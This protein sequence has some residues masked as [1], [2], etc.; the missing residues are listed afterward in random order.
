MKRRTLDVLFSA[1]GLAFA[2][3]FV[4]LGV[5]LTNQSNFAKDYV[6]DQLKAQQI[7]FTPAE[8]LGGEQ[9]RPG[10]ECLVTY[11][12]KDMTTGKMAEC[13]ANQY[14]AAHVEESVAGM[15][16]QYNRPDYANATYSSLGSLTRTEIPAAI[17]AA[18]AKGEDTTALEDELAAW[19]GLRNGTMF[20]G[21]TLRGLLLTT[22]G[23][24]IFGERA[25]Q[26]AMVCYVAA[27]LLVLLSIAG[28]VHALVTPKD[29]DVL[30]HVQ[31][32]EL[33]PQNA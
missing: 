18:T 11:A 28:F 22:Y 14:I 33:Q 27:V 2:L 4:I 10:G 17:E 13:Y 6:H 29:K 20:Q 23:F 25:S 32:E 5:V 7:T 9:D 31:H 16:E 3:L 8:F 24:S 21:E 15:A 30:P 1:G 26:A 19:N 12:G